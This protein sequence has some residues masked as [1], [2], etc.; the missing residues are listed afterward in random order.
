MVSQQ[1]QREKKLIVIYV[2][3][4]IQTETGTR[5]QIFQNVI[6]SEMC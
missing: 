4:Q 6:M 5:V 3:H 2:I 1:A